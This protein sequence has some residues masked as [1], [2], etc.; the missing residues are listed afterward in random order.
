MCTC[1]QGAGEAAGEQGHGD[2][3]GAGTPHSQETLEPELTLQAFESLTCCFHLT[4][5]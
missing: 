1:E 4:G 2:E 5:R 3:A